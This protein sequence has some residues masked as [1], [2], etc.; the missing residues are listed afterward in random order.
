MKILSPRQRILLASSFFCSVLLPISASAFDLKADEMLTIVLVANKPEV[1]QAA[2]KAYTDQAFPLANSH[3][4]REL[5]TFKVENTLVGNEPMFASGLYLWPNKESANKS[6]TDPRYVKDI[7]PLRQVAWK[8][9]QS[10]DVNITAPLSL[11]I[12]KSKVYS[13]A[14][15]WVIGRSLVPAPPARMRAFIRQRA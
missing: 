15:V 13:L 10:M 7:A 8:Q 2:Q 12:D 3:G 9:L 14:L 6:R 4:M 5:T 11:A 1:D